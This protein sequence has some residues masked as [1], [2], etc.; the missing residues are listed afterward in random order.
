MTLRQQTMHSFCGPSTSLD[1]DAHKNNKTTVKR[2]RQLTSTKTEF[3]G[4]LSRNKTTISSFS[5]FLFSTLILVKFLTAVGEVA[6]KPQR[7]GFNH[8]F[9]S[10]PSSDEYIVV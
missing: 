8:H 2:R 10:A 4:R 5:S 1:D 7:N 3:I 9:S 6:A